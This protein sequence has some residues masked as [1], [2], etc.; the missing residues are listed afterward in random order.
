MAIE[1]R[2][3]LKTYFETGDVPTQ[4]QFYNFI[5]SYIHRE[6]D[7]VFIYEPDPAT[8]RFGIGLTAM[9]PA[10]PLGIQA[11]GATEQLI[12][13]FDSGL[14]PTHVWTINRNPDSDGNF[15]FNIAQETGLGSTSRL[16]IQ[17]STGNVGIGTTD[18]DDRLHIEHSTPGGIT[19]LRILNTASINSFGWAEGQL[20]NAVTERDGALV[21]MELGQLSNEER[22]IIRVGGNVGINEEIPDTKLHV[23]RPVSDPDAAIDLRE[24]T[25]IGIFGPITENLVA[26]YRGIQARAGTFLPGNVLDITA[27]QLNLQRMGGSILIHGDAAIPVTNQAIITADAKIGLGNL[28]PDE[29]IVVDGAIR[30]GTAL[31]TTAGTIRFTGTDFEGRVGGTWVSFT[32]TGSSGPWTV[33]LNEEIYYDA[34]STPRV[35]IGTSTV[36]ATLSVLDEE[37]TSPSS[38]AALISSTATSSGGGLDDNRV[39][40]KLEDSGSW[41]GDAFS[42]SIGLYISNIE[43]AAEVNR[44]IAAVLNGNVL[45]GDLV[46]GGTDVIG[47]N[48]TKVLALQKGTKPGSLPTDTV[49]LLCDD[50]TVSGLTYSTLQVITENGDTVRLYKEAPVTAAINDAFP[51][52]Y[53]DAI[54]IL[55]NMRTR[56]NELEARLAAI[57]LLTQS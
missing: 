6:Q 23:T 11:Q 18:P 36:A 33:G 50:V 16:F 54:T 49:Q 47:T 4:D 2:E 1:P 25:G 9:Q 41:G 13:L 14:N 20:Q 32:D 44:D 35:G 17:E 12:S 5:D 27:A 43:G 19:G 22:M 38:I 39:V 21:F 24:G 51:A 46:A 28:A 30:I 37:T 31:G 56:I 29:R 8:K 52:D 3:V 34:A 40:L 55:D 26:D 48:G 57:G 53:P 15:G 45:I 42:K 7:G 10:A